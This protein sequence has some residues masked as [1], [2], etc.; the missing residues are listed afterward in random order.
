MAQAFKAEIEAR[1][2]Y[3]YPPF[4]QFVKFTYRVVTLF[5]SDKDVSN[6]TIPL[7]ER[8]REIIAVYF[9]MALEGHPLSRE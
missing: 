2:R 9:E 1:R 5:R 3:G 7:P 8:L 6:G 4:R